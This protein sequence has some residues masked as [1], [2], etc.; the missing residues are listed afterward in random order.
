MQ[1]T[2]CSA[3]YMVGFVTPPLPFLSLPLLKKGRGDYFAV[4]LIYLM[5]KLMD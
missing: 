5:H 4:L 2:E 3:M 1:N